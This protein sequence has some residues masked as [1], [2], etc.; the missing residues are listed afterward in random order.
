MKDILTDDFVALYGRPDVIITDP[1]R[2]G[3]HNDVI[4]TILLLPEAYCIRLAVIQQRKLAMYHFFL[5]TI[6]LPKY[7]PVDMFPQTHHVEKCS[8]DGKK[9]LIKFYSVQS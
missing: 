4:S 5:Q 9:Q 6:I 1:P 2:A 3:M 8:I 7:Q